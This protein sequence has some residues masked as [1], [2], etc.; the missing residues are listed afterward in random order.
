MKIIM[1]G[2]VLLLL[3]TKR[4]NILRYRQ[5]QKERIISGFEH[6]ATV[7]NRY[8]PPEKNV[9]AYKQPKCITAQIRVLYSTGANQL[10][11]FTTAV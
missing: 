8:L 3:N 11:N 2:F 10:T 5:Q 1:N 9:C 7:Y 6:T 4:S